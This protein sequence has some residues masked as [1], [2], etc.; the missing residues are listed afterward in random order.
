MSNLKE[1]ESDMMTSLVEN[2]G[3]I[4]GASNTANEAHGDQK[5][6]MYGTYDDGQ[7]NQIEESTLGQP[8]LLSSFAF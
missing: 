7:G 6:I 4:A 1:V 2:Q 5:D 3:L 8:M